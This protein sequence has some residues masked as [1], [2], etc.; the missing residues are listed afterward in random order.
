MNPSSL[1][2][3][4]ITLAL[5]GCEAKQA[6]D[7]GTGTSTRSRPLIVA[8]NY[9]LYFFASEIAGDQAEVVLP[10]IQGDPANWRPGS[11][12][13]TRMQ[14]AD[15]VILNGAG[16]ESWL[17]WVT[18]AEDRLLDSSDGFRDRLI[19]LEEDTVHQH[20]PQG[21]HSHK[22]LA[23]TVWLDPTLAAEQARAVEQSLTGLAPENAELHSANLAALITRLEALDRELHEAFTR[24]DGQPVVF[25]HPVYQ[26]LAS[27]YELDAVSVHWEPEK[28][29]GTRAWLELGELLRRHPAKLMIWEDQPLASTA[30][31]LQRL[32]VLPVVF[33]TASNI[34]DDGDY[35]DVM[36]A[37]I[38]RL[39]LK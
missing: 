12:A 5:V 25:S 21:E 35:F 19:P 20:G 27:R 15:L 24:L 39:I 9:P 38:E 13:I 18:L 32:E 31:R 22:D 8:S 10:E 6:A 23:F 14:S 28:E 36:G 17:D 1:F 26:Y 29:P 34:P 7:D 37:N 33:H 16:Y 4:M 3:L 2:V 11:E 30:D